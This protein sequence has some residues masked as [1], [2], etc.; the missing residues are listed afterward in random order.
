MPLQKG[1]SKQ[2]VSQNIAELLHSYK[3]GGSFAKGKTS[4]K[5]RKMAVAAAFDMKRRSS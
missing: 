2:V 1:K 5:A 3:K 4:A